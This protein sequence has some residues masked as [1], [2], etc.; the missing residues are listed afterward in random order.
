MLLCLEKK[1]RELKRNGWKKEDPSA[2][3]RKMS[4]AKE[5]RRSGGLQ[6]DEEICL[7]QFPKEKPALGRKYPERSPWKRN[8]RDHWSSCF[9]GPWKQILA[10][11]RLKCPVNR[12]HHAGTSAA[13]VWSYIKNRAQT[14]VSEEK[15][16]FLLSAPSVCVNSYWNPAEEGC[17]PGRSSVKFSADVNQEDSVISAELAYNSWGS[18]RATEVVNSADS[19][20]WLKQP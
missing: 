6:R 20:L 8:T 5:C 18:S 3:L 1:Q 10:S 19:K 15:L 16:L 12:G 14:G 2:Q 4:K 7:Y 17:Q 13:L 11:A 9:L